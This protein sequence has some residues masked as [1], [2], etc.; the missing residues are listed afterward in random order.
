M[1]RKDQYDCAVIGG[2][3]AGL[4]LSVQLAGGG[5]KV[6]LFEKEQY[7]FHKVCGEYISLES[8]GF[9]RQLGV[10]LEDWNLPVMKRL[11]VSA[12]GGKLLIQ[13]LPLGGI[14]VSRY[15]LDAALAAIAERSGVEVR[16]H[17]KVNEVQYQSGLF[18]IET[19]NGIFETPVC[20]GAFGKRSNLDVKWKRGF[21]QQKASA[22]DNY[23]GVKYHVYLDRPRDIIALHNFNSG[24]CGVAAI[25]ENKYCICYLTTALSLRNNYN[26]IKR[27]EEALLFKN[28]RIKEVFSAAS[29]LYKEPLAISQISFNKKQQVENHILMAG[30]AAGMIAPLCG[31]GMSMAL[32]AGKLAAQCVTE[33]LKG[34]TDRYDMETRYQ[35]QWKRLF[36]SRLRTGR[37]MQRLFGDEWLT[38]VFVQ[39]VSLFPGMA[40]GIIKR[41]HG[42]AF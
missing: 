26:D 24:Y 28:P 21:V 11:M 36:G 10:P 32:H 37:M 33:F 35:Q 4:A 15:K 8:F 27:M 39:A 18:Y 42:R 22:L 17:T 31:N 29:F 19:N 9:L 20:C 12:P 38:N 14:G 30:D 7:P 25:E 23:I 6:I 2:G 41:T 16:G 1:N 40:K 13:P 5:F 3:L 34:N